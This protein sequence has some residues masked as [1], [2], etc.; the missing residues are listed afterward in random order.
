[1][2]GYF[3]KKIHTLSLSSL[4]FWPRS[5]F[6][7]EMVNCIFFQSIAIAAA[8]HLHRLSPAYI[9]YIREAAIST[10][11]VIGPKANY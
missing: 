2:Y 10:I 11:G 7:L 1:M 4:T 9:V 8:A 3:E 5:V 6:E